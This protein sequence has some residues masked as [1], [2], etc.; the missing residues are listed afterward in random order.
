MEQIVSITK[1]GQLTIP[2]EMRKTFGIHGSSKA[3]VKKS[4]DMILVEPKNNFWS[5]SGSLRSK[6]TLSD[7]KLKDA[8]IAFG[9]S[10]SR[11]R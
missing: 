8:R 5:L 4:G 11:K 3:L 10:W 1:Q 7:R 6:I 2:K 9:K